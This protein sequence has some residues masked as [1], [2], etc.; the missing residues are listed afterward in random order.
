M[1]TKD[2]VKKLPEVHLYKFIYPEAKQEFLTKLKTISE[3]PSAISYLE[4]DMN[5]SLEINNNDIL[6]PFISCSY[7]K[8]EDSYRSPWSNTYFPDTKNEH[9]LSTEIRKL[10][11]ELN[12]LV[13]NYTKFYYNQTSVS[14][15]YI[16]LSGELVSSG[17]TCIILIKN[18][19]ENL[20]KIKSAVLES[21]CIVK[22]NFKKGVHKFEASYEFNSK[23]RYNINFNGFKNCCLKGDITNEKIIEHQPLREYLDYGI[24]CFVIGSNFEKMEKKMRK[25][26]GDVC[27]KNFPNSLDENRHCFSDI[28]Q[29]C[30]I[31]SH[32]EDDV[33]NKMEEI[34][35]KIKSYD[36]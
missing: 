12:K 34:N 23:M 24:H 9:V 1:K 14:S 4:Q 26:L 21:I 3:I 16:S 7:N 5:E 18:N 27:F 13:K 6:G 30:W 35:K 28:S 33:K 31:L 10:E 29:D 25:N 19:I 32:L 20:P 22:V 8:N 2:D 15:V 17:F 11:E 36:K